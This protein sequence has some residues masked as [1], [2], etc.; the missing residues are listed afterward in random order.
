MF[1]LLLSGCAA[2][3]SQALSVPTVTCFGD[4]HHHALAVNHKRAL[5]NLQTFGHACGIIRKYYVEERELSQL[6]AAA[7]EGMGDWLQDKHEED[8]RLD[9]YGMQIAAGTETDLE[10]FV[11]QFE[12]IRDATGVNPKVVEHAAIKGMVKALDPHSAFM[13]PDMYREIQPGTKGKFGGVGVQIGIKDKRLTVIAPIDNS[14]AQRAGTQKGDRITKVNDEPTVGLTLMDLVRRL[15]G[16]FG[17]KLTLTIER[18]GVPEPLLFE[19]IREVVRIESVQA[20]VIDENIGYIRLRQFQESTSKKLERTLRTFRG[21]NIQALI[22]DLRNNP[23]GLLTTA[24]GVAEHFVGPG[25]LIVYIKN[26]D[27]RKDEYVSKAKARPKD[28]PMIVLVNQGSAAASEIVAGA[29]QDWGVATIVGTA[30]FGMG[31][32]QTILPL[33]DGSALRLTTAKFYTPKGR[34]IDERSK[35]QPDV[36]VEAQDEIDAPLSAA[37]AHIKEI[38]RQKPRAI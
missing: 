32:I 38:L 1:P 2:L 13:S 33:S 24:V 15:R 18:E 10:T 11:R 31:T 29:L 30:T 3:G 4:D 16:P 5:A 19:L 21:E 22:L 12:F 23:G 25:K 36:A 37:E 8:E 34:P 26:Q 35:I 9:P 14:P 17:A 6:L 20:K 28:R 7:T 27:G